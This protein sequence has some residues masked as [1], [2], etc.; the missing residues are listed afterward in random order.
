ML[1]S[2]IEKNQHYPIYFITDDEIQF[3]INM[4]KLYKKGMCINLSEIQAFHF[5]AESSEVILSDSSF[6][7]C[8]AYLGPQ[9]NITYKFLTNIINNGNNK[10][11][12]V[13]F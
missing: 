6:S 11:Q 3:K 9:K 13:K 8:A 10:H 4:P 1:R 2:V 12:W 7:F 5:I